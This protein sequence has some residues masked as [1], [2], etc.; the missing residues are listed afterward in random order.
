MALVS[1]NTWQKEL[2]SRMPN[3]SSGQ[4]TLE[5]QAALREFFTKS[6]MWLEEIAIDYWK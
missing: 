3:T 1:I 4:I 2:K 5:L 6:G